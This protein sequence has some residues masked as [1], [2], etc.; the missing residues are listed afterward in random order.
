MILR[1]SGDYTERL[2]SSS[3]NP[4]SC[5]IAVLRGLLKP[6][7]MV[8]HMVWFRQQ[9]LYIGDY[10]NRSTTYLKKNIDLDALEDKSKQEIA[11]L[12][13]KV[14]DRTYSTTRQKIGEILME[15]NKKSGLIK[16]FLAMNNSDDTSS[17]IDETPVTPS[18]PSIKWTNIK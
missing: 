13:L 2:A 5:R 11:E 6:H 15:D 10:M 12:I 9:Q 17:Y 16:I 8:T 7:L 18:P 3:A 4:Y 1:E 14:Y